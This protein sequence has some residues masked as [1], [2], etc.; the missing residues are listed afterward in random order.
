[1]ER[2]QNALKLGGSIVGTL[3]GRNHANWSGQKVFLGYSV[4]VMPDCFWVG[5]ALVL[6]F[7]AFSP[8]IDFLKTNRDN[9]RRP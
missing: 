6:G 9:M 1:M 7:A 8:G 5:I 2:D 4:Y 3:I